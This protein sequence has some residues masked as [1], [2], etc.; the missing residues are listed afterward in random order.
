MMASDG[1]WNTSSGRHSTAAMQHHGCHSY[2]ELAAEVAVSWS[3]DTFVELLLG[4]LHRH[5]LTLTEGP[6]ASNGTIAA[7]T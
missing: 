2:E 1:S 5:E 3:N 6:G 7:F 4:M